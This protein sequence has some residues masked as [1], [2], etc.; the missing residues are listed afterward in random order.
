MNLV[1]EK[2]REVLLSV[3]PITIIVLILHFTITP[4]ERPLLL[5]FLIGAV[6]VIIGLSIFLAGVD[7]GITP[8]GN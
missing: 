5:R 1:T 8:I 3:L 7:I 6:L 2:L 4:M